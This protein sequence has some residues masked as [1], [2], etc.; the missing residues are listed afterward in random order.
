[1][2]KREES[3]SSPLFSPP[4]LSL[5]FSVA[6]HRKPV[7]Y[8][9][10]STLVLIKP[11]TGTLE[12]K[13]GEEEEEEGKEEEE[14]EEAKSWQWKENR[15][16]WR[17]REREREREREP[18]QQCWLMVLVRRSSVVSCFL[19]SLLPRLFLT[20]MIATDGSDLNLPSLPSLPPFPTSFSPS[21]LLRVQSV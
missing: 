14:E 11:L 18:R 10:F 19:V 4:L 7:A 21:I 17:K 3:D 13:G 6:S 9:F 1:M 15:K 16:T 20:T 5:S 12:R 8:K 2:G